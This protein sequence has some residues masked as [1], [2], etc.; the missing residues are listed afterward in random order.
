VSD[1]KGQPAES[2]ASEYERGRRDGLEQAAQLVKKWNFMACSDADGLAFDIRALAATPTCSVCGLTQD[3][4]EDC[5]A[6]D[7]TK[8][9][10]E[11]DAQAAA[12]G[13]KPAICGNKFLMQGSSS[14]GI[15]D[16]YSYDACEL[17]LGH[18][19]QHSSKEA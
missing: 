10:D 5:Y 19:G 11:V 4:T 6:N 7:I 18:T 16:A 9:M 8:L 17:P 3:H 14:L 2:T 12:P 13:G 15:P 1:T